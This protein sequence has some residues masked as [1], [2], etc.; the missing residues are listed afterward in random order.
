MPVRNLAFFVI[1]LPCQFVRIR[2]KENL[3]TDFFFEGF[4]EGDDEDDDDEDERK[5][6]EDGAGLETFESTGP[7]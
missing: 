4:E 7:Q 1:S 6:G 3:P 2:A 5:G